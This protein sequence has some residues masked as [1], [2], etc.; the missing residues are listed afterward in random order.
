MFKRRNCSFLCWYVYD[1]HLS[2]F[3]LNN[4]AIYLHV[5]MA[6]GCKHKNDQNNDYRQF[7]LHLTSMLYTMKHGQLACKN[8]KLPCMMLTSMSHLHIQLEWG[9]YKLLLQDLI[10]IG[11][12]DVHCVTFASIFVTVQ[13]IL[14]DYGYRAANIAKWHHNTD[15]LSWSNY[16]TG[17][18]TVPLTGSRWKGITEAQSYNWTK[19][20]CVFSYNLAATMLVSFQLDLFK[21]WQCWNFIFQAGWQT[22]P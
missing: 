15:G 7:S 11:V 13:F 5:K 10:L 6:N 20:C 9:V 21:C 3:L 14:C 16:W 12:V 18:C 1:H 22:Y 2:Y 17:I 4:L 19:V 8:I